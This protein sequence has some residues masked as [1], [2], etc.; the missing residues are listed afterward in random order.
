M[1]NVQ[2]IAR[3]SP[4]KQGWRLFHW[5][6]ALAMWTNCKEKSTKTRIA[7]YRSLILHSQALLI[8]RKSPLKQGLRQIIGFDMFN[9]NWIARK[10]PIKQG[11][12]LHHTVLCSS[13]VSIARKSPL[14]QGLRHHPNWFGWST[15]DY[16]CKEK[17]TKTRIATGKR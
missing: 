16:N 13:N 6:V 3:K 7:T 11:L 4:L 8:A 14:K 9:L 17:S 10:S 15:T 2:K 1:N 5:E 12:R